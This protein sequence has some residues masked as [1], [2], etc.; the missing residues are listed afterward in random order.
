[1]RLVLC[2]VVFPVIALAQSGGG[3]AA[4]EPEPA[5]AAELKLENITE[6]DPAAS[7]TDLNLLGEVDTESGEARRNENVQIDLI[8][9][10]VLKEMNRRIGVTA[11]VVE[12]FQA[13]SSYFGTEFGGPASSPVALPFSTVR[14]VHGSVFWNHDNS[15]LRARSFFQV[16][17]VQ[18][19]R[20]NDYGFE[21]SA[22]AWKGANFTFT[23]QQ[24][25]NSG[26]VNGNVL[27]PTGAERTPHESV[28]DP[29]LRAKIQRMLDS[30]P[31]ELPNRPDINA[32]ALNT[33]AL[34]SIDNDILSGALHQGIGEKDHLTMRYSFTGQGV[35]AFQLVSGQN[36]NSQTRNHDA[37]TTWTR[38][39]SPNTETNLTAA[40][41]RVGSVLSP[42][43]SAFGPTVMMGGNYDDLGPGANIPIDRTVNRYRTAAALRHTASRHTWTFGGD[44]WRREII[45]AESNANRGQFSFRSDFGNDGITN[46][47]KGLPTTYIETIGNSHR[48]FSQFE[49]RFYAGDN[50]RVYNRLTLNLGLRYEYWTAPSEKN[51]LSE[52]PFGCDCDN[53]APRFG[54]AARPSDRWGVLRGAYGIQYAEVYPTTFGAIRFNTPYSQRLRVP[55]PKFVNPLGPQQPVVDPTGRGTFFNFAPDLNSPYSHQYNLSW[56]V[57]LLR[58]WRL[59][60]GYVGSRTWKLITL[61][62]FNR[63]QPMEGMP[64]TT[65]NLN[66]RRPDARYFDIRTALNGSRAYYDAGKATLIAPSRGGFTFETS[67]WLSKAIDLGADYTSTAAGEDATSGR[68]QSE[69]DVHSD[70]RGLSN[71]DQPH[72][73]LTRL[74]WRSPGLSHSPG[75]LR[76]ALGSWEIFAVGLV[77]T[78]TPFTISTG[79]DGPGFGNVDGSGSDRPN[80]VDPSILGRKV[81]HPDTSRSLLPLDAF[82]FIEPTEQRGNIGRNTFRKDG[83]QNLN[84]AVSRTWPIAAEARL[85][86]RAESNNVLNRPQFAAP[87]NEIVSPNFGQITNTLN[88]GRTFRF[89]LRL[90]F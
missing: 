57:P 66:E 87:G 18:P 68:G 23:G 24:T 45:G 80:I 21:A 62:Y 6:V 43:E 52:F 20:V 86:L 28:T 39:W 88:D 54:F 32:R 81:K 22:P 44:L 84:A 71:F 50:W 31:N 36:P 82:G 58:D 73:W 51:G 7:R 41:D 90:G 77:K 25:R 76:S 13:E 1:M 33:N 48:A 69:F 59:N 49:G 30:Y 34:Q 65:A 61:W 63:S 75:W 56:E 89:L 40:F 46:I 70:M 19:A 55:A 3:E 60:L 10:N 74:T 79:S 67:Y 9:N 85:T 17:D 47:R 72:S 16:G 64:Q 27:V 14:A 12:E 42:D 83:I 37:R 11:T 5:P 53:V 35:D 15:A 78:G 2:L 38:V 8:D 29:L 4:S 26:Q